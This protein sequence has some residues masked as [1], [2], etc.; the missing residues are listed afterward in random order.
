VQAQ[1]VDDDRQPLPIGQVGLLGGRSAL[2]IEGYLDDPQ[3]DAR[4]I[5]EGWFYPG[6]SA[7]MM[8]KNTLR[9]LGRHDEVL[10]FGGVK[11]PPHQVEEQV[12]T[13]EGVKEVAALS[14]TRPDTG[15]ARLCLAIVPK[16][17]ARNQE[18]LKL[19]PEV[20]NVPASQLIM[21]IVKSLPYTDNGKLKR[22]DLKSLFKDKI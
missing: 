9:V 4:L 22:Q 3:A 12:L 6:D 18:I 13:V 1:V 17:G 19:V 7:M 5:H 10:N 14:D 21:Q 2:S 15:V 20:V 16:P 8:S 11:V